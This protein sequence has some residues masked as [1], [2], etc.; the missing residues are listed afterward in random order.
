[1][2]FGIE[3]ER[4]ADL[5]KWDVF[6]EFGDGCYGFYLGIEFGTDNCSGER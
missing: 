3:G 4:D 6:S 2:V 1:M 5:S